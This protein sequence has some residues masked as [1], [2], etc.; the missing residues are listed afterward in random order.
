[1]VLYSNKNGAPA[2]QLNMIEIIHKLAQA[3]Q[4]PNEMF[5]IAKPLRAQ[6]GKM[7]AAGSTL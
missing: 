7:G 1:M 5:Q 3:C 2:H 4:I 6:R